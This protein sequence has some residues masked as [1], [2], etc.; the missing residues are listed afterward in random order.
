[1]T[2]DEGH[3]PA[4]PGSPVDAAWLDE[5]A[6]ELVTWFGQQTPP[7]TL[8]DDARDLDLFAAGLMDEFLVVL[9]VQHIE[10]RYRVRVPDESMGIEPLATVSR[11]AHLVVRLAE[12]KESND[13]G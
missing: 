1:M 13:D 6:A 2:V 10:E 9:M 4:G 5:V 12:E 3:A 7:V 11:I 8:P